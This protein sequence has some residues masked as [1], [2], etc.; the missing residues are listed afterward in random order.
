MN[1]WLRDMLLA[2]LIGALFAAVTIQLDMIERKQEEIGQIV[3]QQQELLDR[4]EQIKRRI[5]ALVPD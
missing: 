3:R 4:L 5:R 1:R 2:A